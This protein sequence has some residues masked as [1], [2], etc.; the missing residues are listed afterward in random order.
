MLR[1]DA[2]DKDASNI[3]DGTFHLSKTLTCQLWVQRLRPQTPWRLQRSQTFINQFTIDL[4]HVTKVQHRICIRGWSQCN[5]LHEIQLR[6]W[7]QQA[8]D[9]PLEGFIKYETASLT[10]SN[11]LIDGCNTEINSYLSTNTVLKHRH[12]WAQSTPKSIGKSLQTLTTPANT[13]ALRVNGASLPPYESLFKVM[14]PFWSIFSIS[15]QAAVKHRAF[16]SSVSVGN[17]LR[18]NDVSAWEKQTDLS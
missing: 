17:H 11:F 14:Q 5:R 15:W 16:D 4:I 7:E 1:T 8:C 6:S 9:Q 18:G 2:S 3:G 13:C 12:F 10:F